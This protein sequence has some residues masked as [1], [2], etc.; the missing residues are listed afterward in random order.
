[1][2]SMSSLSKAKYTPNLNIFSL[3]KNK[4]TTSKPKVVEAKKPT[5]AGY[6]HKSSDGGA[7]NNLVF[8]SK[9][10]DMKES[11]ELNILRDNC[12]DSSKDMKETS[13]HSFRQSGLN[14]TKKFK[15]TKCSRIYLL[16]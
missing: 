5:D 14:N 11:R 6:T 10:K 4:I 9:E 7:R 16:K 1:M 12:K 13:S 3:G 15:T 8:S 2:S